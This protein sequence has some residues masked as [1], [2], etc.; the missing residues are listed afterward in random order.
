MVSAVVRRRQST[1]LRVGL[2]LSALVG[3]SAKVPEKWTKLGVPSEG[4][5]AVHDRTSEDRFSADYSGHTSEQ[6]MARVESGLLAASYRR[7][8]ERFEGRVRGYSKGAESLLVQIDQL[9]SVLALSVGNERGSDKMLYG[10]C[11]GG[12]ELGPP[13]RIK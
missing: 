2:V 3:C 10:I 5:E 7:T 6:L 11:F 1:V 9:G 12:L 13:Q 4:L 8:C